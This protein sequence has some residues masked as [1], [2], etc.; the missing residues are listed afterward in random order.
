MTIRLRPPHLLA[1]LTYQS[2]GDERAKLRNCKELVL[3]LVQGEC[4]E[5]VDGPDDMGPLIACDH[6]F[7]CA[8]CSRVNAQSLALHEA[9]VLLGMPLHL[10]ATIRLNDVQLTRLEQ[11][12]AALPSAESGKV[13]AAGAMMQALLGEW[14]FSRTLRDTATLAPIGRMQGTAH[15]T[16]SGQAQAKYLE[17]GVLELAS[18]QSFHGSCSYYFKEQGADLLIYFDAQ[19][20]RLFHRLR[21]LCEPTGGLAAASTH[22]CSA[23]RYD[24]HY[25]FHMDGSFTITHNVTGPRKAYRSCTHYQRAVG[26]GVRGA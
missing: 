11:L 1:I 24:S 2:K 13:W 22:Q 17:K 12:N 21:P 26:S 8:Q 19:E 7:A 3:R 15:F 16:S 6:N 23:D 20:N 9:E 18:G 5:V 4:I 25:E 10:G 14:Q